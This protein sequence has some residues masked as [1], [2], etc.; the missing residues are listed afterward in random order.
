MGLEGLKVGRWK[1]GRLRHR[2]LFTAHCHRLPLTV[3][4]PL[5]ALFGLGELER[6]DQGDD[7]D[8]CAEEVGALRAVG[9][10]NKGGD[11]RADGAGEG[12]GGAV[13][14]EAAAL[15]GFGGVE[16]DQAAERG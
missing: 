8:E 9:E 11:E 10:V 15:L 16:R 5:I 1:V 7:D 13:D 6:H 4:R 3:H 12:S 14:A 2:P